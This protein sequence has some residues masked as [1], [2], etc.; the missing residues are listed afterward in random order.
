MQY[1]LKLNTA[2]IF[3]LRLACL[4][5]AKKE[6]ARNTYIKNLKI[7]IN[8]DFLKVAESFK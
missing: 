1:V 2:A 8:S 3:A 6:L 5:A 4:L 7:H